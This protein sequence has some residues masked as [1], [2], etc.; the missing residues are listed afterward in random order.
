MEG[1]TILKIPVNPDVRIC[2]KLRNF[3]LLKVLDFLMIMK[4]SDLPKVGEDLRS[5]NKGKTKHI[6]LM[7]GV[8]R[9]MDWDCLVSFSR[10]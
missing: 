2:C 6:K 9:T 5:T 1:I 7:C 10:F 3:V 4:I 8:T